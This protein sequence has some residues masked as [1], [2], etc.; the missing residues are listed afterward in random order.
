MLCTK[1]ADANVSVLFGIK[2][3]TGDTDE[4]DIDGIRFETEFQPGSGSW[5]YLLGAAMS[6][7]NGK[8]GF[9]TNILYN[10]TTEGSQSTKIGDALSYNAAFNYRFSDSHDGHNHEHHHGF[11]NSEAKWQLIIE[12]NGET[13]RENKISGVEEKHSGG[14]TVYASPGIRVSS[15]KFS[16]F[17]SYGIPVIENQNGEQTD[18][19]SRIVGGISF[20]I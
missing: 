12:L 7:N 1:K 9:H 15:G 16:G 10:K 14:T 18:V 20:A 13:R 17:I 4:K 2:A 5:D 8:F 6:I 19:D 11:T 3:P